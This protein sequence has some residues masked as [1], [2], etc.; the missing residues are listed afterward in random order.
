ML[1][2]LKLIFSHEY[3]DDI[4]CYWMKS[5][6]PNN[7]KW[8]GKC[9][10]NRSYQIREKLELSAGNWKMNTLLEMDSES[11]GVWFMCS[12]SFWIQMI[13]EESFIKENSRVTKRFSSEI[14]IISH[15]TVGDFRGFIALSLLP[16]ITAVSSKYRG[17][18]G[19]GSS[20]DR[21]VVHS[22]TKRL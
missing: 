22:T 9:F 8:I 7:W 16:L 19:F 1:K 5:I 18:M 21:S 4:W 6:G 10:T 2:I 11:I 15:V 3:L 20:S 14:T 17:V 13:P 12:R